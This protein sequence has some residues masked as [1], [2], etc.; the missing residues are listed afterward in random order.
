MMLAVGRW[1]ALVAA[2]IALGSALPS[3]AEAAPRT[4]HLRYGPVDL[5]PAEVKWSTRPVHA[6][7]VSGLITRMHAFVTNSRGH[8]LASSQVMLH[9]AVFRR[10]IKPRW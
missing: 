4:F 9:H 7:A 2:L 1:M 6:P 5:Q 3:V 10:L 8:R